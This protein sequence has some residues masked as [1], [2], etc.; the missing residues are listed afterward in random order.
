MSNEQKLRDYLKRV[1][2]DLHQVRQRLSEVEDNEREPIAIVGM[3]CRFP[4]GVNSP[5]GL[6]RLL[7]DGTDA[8]SGFPGNRGWDVDAL[9]DPDP[10]HR[11]TA[12]VREG[13]F[14]HD[15][16]G[17][18]ASLFGISPREAAAMD[19]QQRLLLEASWEVFERAGI[20]PTSV[21]GSRTGVFAGTS[22]QDYGSELTSIPPEVEGYLGTGLAAA[23]LSGR[24]AYTFGLEGPAVTVDTACSSSLVAL[25]LAAQALRNGE[26]TMAL[27]GG[28][29]V[30]TTPGTFVEFSRQRGLASD[31]RC[32]AFAAAA[33]GTGWGEG[34][35]VLLVERLSDARRNGHEVLALLRGSAVNQD[36]ASS[37]LTAPNGPSQ[38]RV[39]RQALASARLSPSQVD[40]V[41]AHGTGTTLG[42]PIEAQ[43]LL[44]TYG[45]DR[46]RPLWLGSVKSNIGHTQAAAGVAGVIKMVEA[47]RHGV[48]PKTLHVDEPTP[49]V[50]WSSGAVSLLT[51]SVAWPE[52]GAPRRAAVSAFGVSGTNVHTVLEQAPVD[53]AAEEPRVPVTRPVPWVLAGRT[54]EA[55]RAQAAELASTVDGLAP[56]D[57]AFSLATTRAALERRAVVVGRDSDEFLRGLR[58]LAEGSVAPNL[59]TGA[60]RDDASLAVLFSGQGSQRAGMGRELYG[61]FPVFASALDAVCAEL[62]RHLD[63][64]I[65]EL[66]FAEDGEPLNQTQYTQA[67]L[68]ALE[69]AL[70]RLVESWGIRPDFVTGHSIGELTAAHVAG[71]LSLPDAAVLVA[72]RGRFMQAL[73]A[74]GA[75]L[76]VQAT[77]NE[78]KPLLEGL[79]DKVSIAAV[80]GPR[81]VVVAG[82]EDVIAG[83]ESAWIWKTKRLTVSHAFHSP[84][85]E[86]M[87]AD[88]RTIAQAVTLQAP[89]IPVVS[90]VT[91]ETADVTDPEYWVRHVRET[92]RFADGV[93]YLEGQGVSAF[94][95]LGPDGILTGM[96]AESLS[97]A[98]LVPALRR[99]RDEAEVLT[100][101]L[102]RLHAAGVRIDWPA[103]FDGTGAH[104][105]DLPT[106]A[107]QHE[108]Y[109]LENPDE[110][111]READEVDGH[112]WDAVEREDL[113]VLASTL[114]VGVDD[115]LSAVL[116]ALSAW[117]RR[118]REQSTVDG[119][120][121]GV[122]WRAI[123]DPA[124]ALSG[125]WLLVLPDEGRFDEA[126]RVLRD[127]GAQ[128]RPLVLAEADLDRSSLAA[129]LA[130]LAAD[131]PFAGVLSL[132][133]LDERPHAEFPV[134]PLGLSG[135]LTLVQA[136]EESGVDGP[137]WTVTSGA[138]TTGDGAPVNPVQAQIWGLARTVP[139][140]HPERWG[141][142]VDLPSEADE[143][144]WSRLAG[145]LAAGGGEDQVAVRASGVFGRRLVHAPAADEAAWSCDG[146]VLVTGGT[147]AL[148]AR[149]ARW[150]VASGAEHVVLTSRRGSD[151]EGA[152]ELEAELV[153]AGARVTIAACD[154]A[155]RE[156]A[157][158][159]V[160]SLT[161]LSAV[162]HVAGVVDDGVLDSL[163]LERVARVLQP[164]VAGAVNL[165]ELTAGMDLSAFV[166]FSSFSGTMG[167]PGQ[168]GYA[169][170][171]AFLDA[172]AE[173]RHA[174]GLPATSIAWGPWAGAGMA[175]ADAVTNRG[176]A[177]SMPLLDPE[178]ALT[179]MGRI[180]AR[181]ETCVGIVDLDWTKFAAG[182]PSDTPVPL[183]DEIPDVRRALEAAKSD[184]DT[185]AVP[186]ASALARRLTGLS[187]TERV[188]VL[189]DVVRTQ[190]AVVLGHQHGGQIEPDRAF[191]DLGF[192][193][194]SALEFRNQLGAAV[195]LSLPAT[196]IFDYPTPLALAEHLAGAALGADSAPVAAAATDE[197]IAIIGMSCRFPGGVSTPEQL[198]ELLVSGTDALTEFPADRGWDIERLYHPDRDANEP[199][200]SYTR[201]GGFL[202]DAAGFDSNFFGIS[203]R[204]ALAMD[205]QQRLLLE[206][207]W[208]A[209]ERAGIDPAAMRGSQTGVFAGSSGQDYL[210]VVAES[211]TGLGGHLGT[212]N[213]ASVASGRVSYTFG[214]EGPAMTVDTACSSS[215]VALHLACQSLRQGECTMALAGG[216]T[217]MATPGLFVEFS[218]QRGLATDGR[219][220]AF[221]DSADGTGW[222]EGVGLLLVER[223][224]DAQR[225]GH[226]I[227]AVV[228]GSAVNQDGASN[229]LTAPNG[230]SQQR[231][232]RQALANA[233][234]E[235][236]DVDAVEAHGT[237][238]TL[239]DPIEAQALLATYGQG[240]KEPLWLGSVKS[241]IGHT[242]AAAGVAGVIKMVLALRHGVL[243][244]T[245]HVDEPSS[246]VDWSSGA[247]SLVTESMP[248]PETG[249][250]RRAGISSFGFSGT[251]AHT[252]LEQA[253]EA[254]PVRDGAPA[255]D[256]VV[257]WVLSARGPS[258]LRAQAA[259]LLSHTGAHPELNTADIAFSLAATR[260]TLDTRA[261]VLGADREEL[262]AGLAA[263]A[264]GD[265]AAN[266][267]EGL[268]GGASGKVAFVFPG[269]GSQW[270][271]M[272]T[273]LL[274]SSA[275]FASRFAE[276]EHALSSFVDWSLTEAV[277]DE[278][279]L[280][281]VDVVQPVLWAVMVS[282]AEVW[283]SYGVEPAA[284][285][286][287]S[288][289]EIAA[290][291]VAGALSLEDGA[292]V[293]ALRSQTIRDELAGQGGM[294]S[295]AQPES[296]VVERIARFGDR[297][298]V[299]AVNG[300]GT[301]VIAGEPEALAEILAECEAE[302]VRARKIAVDYASHTPQVESIRDRL[303][304]VL[305][306]IQPRTGEVGFFSTL[307]GDWQDTT[308]LDAR[309]W[310]E[311]LRHTVKFEQA[312]R[313]LSEQGYGFFVESSAHPVLTMSVQETLDTLET[314]G[315]AVGT[316]RRNE[317]GVD[318]FLTSL[319]EAYVQGLTVDWASSFDGAARVDLP[320]YAFQHERYWPEPVAAEP[321]ATTDPMADRFWELVENEDLENLVGTLDVNRDAPL[322]DVLP[323]L[324]AWRREHR[325]QSVVDGWRYRITWKRLGAD[326]PPSLS[327]TWLVLGSD[328]S[329]RG[330]ID[331][332]RRHGA[333]T[334]EVTP[335]DLADRETM[336]AA[337]REAMDGAGVTP[338][339]VI[340]VWSLLA[341]AENPLPDL[342]AV[343]SGMAGTLTLLQALGDL[344]VDA[345]LWCA[346]RG[347]VAVTGADP[348]DH[349]GQALV[350]GLGRIAGLEYE[351][352][353]GGLVDLPDAVGE[354]AQD[355]LAGVLSG[356]G[357]EDQL[358]IRESGVYGRRLVRARAGETPVKRA[359]RPTGTAL[360][361]GGTGALGGQVARWLA[362]NGAEHLLLLSRRGSDAPG[363]AELTDE[364]TALGARVTIAACDVSDRD[365]LAAV[366][367]EIPAEY[368]L[369]S[370]LHTAAVLDDT[371]LELL[372]PAQIDRVLRV[373]MRAAENL[374]ELTGEL[375]A[376]VLFSSLSGTLGAS[377]QGNYAPGNAYLDALAHH[378]RAR[379]Q[380]ATSVAWGPWDG[381]GMAESGIGEIA[382]RHGVPPMSPE[383]AVIALQQALDRD[384]TFLTVADI[385]WERY[386]VAYTATRPTGLFDELAEVTRLLAAKTDTAGGEREDAPSEL[387]G[388]LAGL[389]AAEQNRLL[390]ELV[391]GHVA[392]VLGYSSADA[393]DERRSFKDLG[394]DSVTA[395]ELRNRLGGATG[396]RLPAT[397]VFDYPA[398]ADLAAYLRTEILGA[399]PDSPVTTTVS[400][401]ADEPVAIVAMSCRFPGGVGSPEDLWRLVSGSGDA[402]GELP[403]DRGWDLAAL[404]DDD[405]GRAGTSYSRA[406]G[407]LYEAAEFDPGLFGISPREALA[408]DPQQR[409]VLEAAW[410][411]FERGG[412]DP[413]SLRGSDAGVFLGACSQGYGS[414]IIE[415][416]EGV[417]GYF[418]TGAA[419]S[420]MSG[421]IAY[422][423]GL[424]GP[425][426]TVDTACSSSLVALHLAAQAL[427]AGE[428][429]LAVAGGVTVM[430]TPGSFSEFSRQRGLAADGKCKAFAASADGFGQGEGLGLLLM[431]RLSDAKR[432]GHQVLAVL[433]GSAVNQDGASNGLTAPN[434]PSQQRVIRQALA[435]ARLEP[436][437][438]DA[439]EA[440]G[441][442]TSLGDPIEAQ[443]VLATYGQ[444][445]DE[446][447]W[448]GSVKSNIGH[449]Q[450]AAGVAGVIKMVLAMR[451]G[452]LPPTLH[453]DEP[454][455]HVDWSSGAVSLVTESMPWPETGRPRRVGVSSFGF[456]GTNAH[457]ILEQAEPVEVPAAE[458]F[459]GVVPWVLSGKT[460]AA[461][462]AQANRLASFAA[463]HGELS[464]ADVGLSLTATR[465]ALES[466]GVVIGS[467]P[468]A[469]LEGLRALASGEVAPNSVAGVAD[470]RG[471]VVFV[472]PGQG[473]QWVG[474]AVDLLSFSAVFASRFAECERAL[475]SFVDWSLT[476]VVGD[477]GALERVDVVQPVLW[478]VMVSLA[479]VWRSFGV[480]PAAVVGH[481][482]GEIAAAVVA[483]A[484][485]LEDGARVVALRSQAIRDEL[486]GKGGMV[487]IAQPESAVV[488]RISRFGDR[489]AVAA[490]NGPGTTVIAGEPEA[491]AEILA[492]C[493]AEEVRARKIA[494]D[495]ASHTPQVESIRDRLL[496][497]LSPIQP[498]GTETG[499]FSTLT[500]DWQDTTGLD[501]R[502]WVE[503]LRHTVKFE[504]ATRALV[505]QGYRFFIESSAHPVLTMSVQETFDTTDTDGVAFGSLRRNEGGLDRFLTS[506]A[507]GYVR[508]LDVDWTPAYPS[509][510]RR[511]ELP[512][513]AFQR[514]RYWLES[515][516]SVSDLMAADVVEARFWD[517]VE[518]EDLEALATTLDVDDA[519]LG[520]L[521][522]ALSS[523]RRQRRQQSTVD[524][525]RYTVSWKPLTTATARLSGTWLLVTAPGHEDTVWLAEELRAHGADV[526]TIE[527]GE[528][529]RAGLTARI[530]EQGEIAGV[531]SLLGT[532][533]RPCAG[534]P[535]LPNGIADTVTL[536]QALVDS[537]VVAPVWLA[538]RGGVSVGRSDRAADP[539]QAQV[540]GLGRILGLEHPDRWGGLLDLPATAD[541]RAAARVVA[542]LAGIEDEDQVAVRDSG[543]FARRLVRSP[544][545]DRDAV[546]EWSP[547]GTVLVTGGTGALGGHVAR[548]LA[549]NGAE[550][551]VLTSRRGRDA[552]GAVELE[553]ALTGLGARVTI[554]ACDAADRDALAEL[555]AEYGP[556]SAVV[557]TAGV[558]QVSLLADQDL[559]D[560][561]STVEAKVAGAA[562]LDE[563]LGDAE[564]DAFV[565]FSS[566]AGVWG[567]GAQG[568]YA[569][570]NAFLDALAE[571]RRARG[572]TA[573]SIAW[574]AW[575]GSGLATTE[576]AEENLRRRGVLP[577]APEAAVAA[578]VQ[579]VEHDETFVAVAD[580]DWARFVP[581]FT[582]ARPR[583]LISDI[584]EARQAAESSYEGADAA[585]GTELVKRLAG[586]SE[587]ERQRTVV[588]LVRTTAAAVLGLAGASEVPP[589]RAFRDLG[590]DSLTAVEIRNRL[591]AATGLKLPTALVFDY[592]NATVLAEFLVREVTGAVADVAAPT[593]VA[594]VGDDPVVIV[595]MACRYPGGVNS[596]EQFWDLV[597]SGGDGISGFPTDRGWDLD[598]IS[599]AG[600]YAPEGGFVYDA[601]EFDAAFFGIS[602]REARAM[603]P[604]Q[605][606]VLEAAWETLERAGIDPSALR[607]SQTGVFVGAASQGYGSGFYQADPDAME[608]YL[609][610][611]DAGSVVSGR[612]S[613]ALGLEGPAVTVDTACSSSL[614]AL[615]WA[616]QSVRSGESSLALAGGVAVMASAGAFAEFGKQ[617][618]LAGDGRCKPFAEAAD[619]TGWGEGVGMVLLERLSDAERNGH[620]VLAVIRGS[621]V[622]QDGASNGLTAPNGPS[623]QRVIR[624][625]L[626]NA[627]LTA[628]EVD[629]VEAH[630]TGTTL[631]DP[632]EAQA[633]LA[634]YG[635]DRERP[636]LL[637][638]VKSNIGHTQ[639]ASGVAG[640]IKMVQA[641]RHGVLP[642]TL[643]IDE[644]STHVD[645]S[646][647]AVSLL[648]DTTPWPETGA[649][650]RAGVSAFGVSGTNVH[651]ILE[652]APASH[653]EE[654]VR[655]DRPLPWVLSGKTQDAVRAQASRLLS[656]V[657]GLN[658]ADIAFSLATT[659]AGLD[660]RAALTG[661]GTGGFGDGLRALADGRSAPGVVTGTA[662]DGGTAILFSGQGSQRAGMGKQLYGEFPV[663]ADALDAVCAYLDKSLDRPV[664]EL[665]FAEDGEQLNQTQYT[666]ASLFA[667]EVALYRLVESW[668]IRPDF[669]TGHSIGE[670]TAAHVAGVLSLED[671]A[672]LVAARGRLM[673]ALPTGGAMLSVRATENDI[674]PLLEGLEDKVSIAA[675][676]GPASVVVAG[677]EDVIAGFESAWEWKTKRLTVSHAFHSPR[678]EPM[679][680]DFRK[681]A[682]SLTFE[683]PKVPVVSNVTGAVADV[684][685][686][687][688]WV[689]HVR[690]AVRFADGVQYLAGQ[691][692]TTFL[693][694]GPDGVLT[695][696]AQD[697]APEATH[698]PALRRDR[699][700]VEATTTAVA[701]L[702]VSGVLLDWQAYFAG[703]GARTVDLPTYPFQRQRYWLEAAEAE[704]VGDD[705]DV[706][707]AQ[708]WDAVEREDLES[709]TGTLRIDG[710]QP[711]SAVLPALSSWRRQRRD[712]STVDDWRYQI[713]WK[714]VTADAE[715]ALS[716]TWLVVVPTEAGEHDW[717]TGALDALASGGAE[718][719]RLDLAESELDRAVLAERIASAVGE[720]PLSGV[721]SLLGF[722]ERPHS[723]D[724][725]VPV[726][727]FGTVSLLQ[728]LADAGLEVPLWLGT[729]GAVS[730]GRSDRLTSPVQAHLWGIGRVIG[731]EQPQRWGGLVDLP[732]T[733]TARLGARL[734]AALAGIDD[735]DQL[736]VR[737]SSV[738]GRRLLRAPAGETTAKWQPKGTV[739]ITGGTGALGGHVARWLAANGAERLV[740]TS[741]RGGAAAG[742]AE[743]E[744]ELTG[745][746][747][748]VSI[749]AC[750]VADRE[751]L[752][753]LVRR[754][755]AE[756]SPIRA[757][758]H[759]AG[760]GQSTSVVDM[761]LA[762]IASVV[763]AKVTG[764]TNLHEL[765]ADGGL[766]AFVLFSSIA[767]VWGSGVQGAYAAGNAYL[768]ALAE[769]RRFDGL[770]ATSV[771]W[772]PW[773]EGGLASGAV[774]EQLLRRGLRQLA[775]GLAVGALVQSVGLDETCVTVADVDWARFV[776]GYTLSGPSALISSVPEAQRA[777]EADA[778]T[779]G[780]DES[781]AFAREI[782]ALSS[783]ERDRKLLNLVRTKVAEVLG[784]GGLDDI[785]AD[786]S[787]QEL[788]FDSLTAVELR[789]QLTSVTGVALPAT[790]VFD[791]PTPTALGARLAEEL[792]PE[793]SGTGTE[794]EADLRRALA[795]IPVDRLREAGLLDTLLRLADSPGPEPA[796]D[797]DEDVDD[798]IDTMDIENLIEI[799]LDGGAAPEAD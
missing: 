318:R 746:G 267:V 419:T 455:P 414:D 174:E 232:I 47:M 648:T 721:L 307:T 411:V 177:H 653:T 208:E 481:S 515:T 298:A 54:D 676:N 40:V 352:R 728:S 738:F 264:G 719:V 6:W 333:R 575:G 384:E 273:D 424:E 757:V 377:G 35:G 50:D 199:G 438:V 381:G 349:P 518:R 715:A 55:L 338:A 579:S 362:E 52:T 442:G 634:T 464:A 169:A 22:G 425:A 531:L 608:G 673:Q 472:F 198:W 19:P 473:S 624:Q 759:T 301:T 356:R 358:A 566:N 601:S 523:W 45:Q 513:Y 632:I 541:D 254:E 737:D 735:E 373:K 526:V 286:G 180:L 448:L 369:T 732:A 712:Q 81:S 149:V 299:A 698:I 321:V 636:L 26:C 33:D 93:R 618:G 353:W 396:L 520:E 340:G 612:V 700:E 427:R 195:V 534:H 305:D 476:E 717:V 82:D 623:Q 780:G 576:V 184:S 546:R 620:E 758:V 127:S 204:E 593:A 622:N 378:R 390:L 106:Y 189:L 537:A 290:A 162:F 1:T 724:P 488:E 297:V 680:A 361:T 441:T 366:L 79:E 730:V 388:R 665:M 152:P 37:G 132:L 460:D 505:E 209:F 650:R 335:A 783:S 255:P 423:L 501:A 150:L 560:F 611:G 798:A 649:P 43:A 34:V 451:H 249:H 610:T 410:E 470:V 185:A 781:A 704:P 591:S 525:W 720:R 167:S 222:G 641:M 418:V 502:Y 159:L 241:N 406:G 535:V 415:A 345:P 606:I 557:H 703:T 543:V 343:P 552:D 790:L 108:H 723:G 782:A 792:L 336:A 402:I 477:E 111:A 97:D 725:A 697:T 603:D 332:L 262:L 778:D 512:T 196:L 659:R 293:V 401:V 243:P 643:H 178:L 294:V 621:A 727:V 688:Y 529:D 285:V 604:Q 679:L 214:F 553:A 323:V 594:E 370:V 496:D 295:I 771:A 596:P 215:L 274:S 789:N 550:H 252:V 172:L 291:V 655:V 211:A 395:V 69:V 65:K 763:G 444:G 163:T 437:E 58:A 279:L 49:Q 598:G 126:E 139:L 707:D 412:I 85:M 393:A 344:R 15:A 186:A 225:N 674:A 187:R 306:P 627:G 458:P 694:L 469:R 389:G 708:F 519:S 117:R 399:L 554:A 330:A 775:P 166:L 60:S 192:D 138:V 77:E 420:V 734:V 125:T 619:G 114:Q 219:C 689:R 70:Y 331:A 587:V 359:W 642:K 774:G 36:G 148:G 733:A 380:V 253:P 639:A 548:W 268:P 42:D 23:V 397:L 164:K 357:V 27:A 506:L 31:G 671:A 102:G 499:F 364:L 205:P 101:A 516:V 161:E 310:V 99:D 561:A 741:R 544:L 453:V 722:D 449:A 532:D 498:R 589:G 137:L 175:A 68:F 220:R 112:F 217:V 300:P 153:A 374:H 736:A 383:L 57:V 122:A 238:T 507:E 702:Y 718:T 630:G 140:E 691:G 456:S 59:V 651:T 142:L 495:Y 244:K 586:L 105:V 463:E 564:L 750:D 706:V 257:P 744:A 585:G 511:V 337:V 171:N 692:V 684:T 764:A 228:R 431:E 799:A 489:V 134:L 365:S 282:L 626:A 772:G 753:A 151:A 542:V 376:F 486:A 239:G 95:E 530:D 450:Q 133:G 421:R 633:V 726:G 308:G 312:T 281:R 375:S 283:R 265:A 271:G 492:E 272:A 258:A 322:H 182:L 487:S 562:H 404:F 326:V 484:L 795:T 218:A 325:E 478:A 465:S 234:L 200:T 38:Q 710:D 592:P 403:S 190:A 256:G 25:H 432:N 563:L 491:L 53:D 745:L 201:E 144:A 146:T 447:V 266:V 652:Q 275:V 635:Q 578:L 89:R 740:L 426:M 645:W 84:R 483:G 493:E 471:K 124:P 540:W 86:P 660:H 197:P 452:V 787:F 130:E 98:A 503:N 565:L 644:P 269:Q 329:D 413:L 317:G 247:V 157:A 179:A 466:R 747:A 339:E 577:M 761:D 96:A 742:A 51:D 221:A 107:F 755:A 714:P 797:E 328:G 206:A 346:T 454:T 467:D 482:Q 573:T 71:V 292:R 504:Q 385:N 347:A 435:N 233:R 63:R 226:P 752:E 607:G 75:M 324:S 135:T 158:E 80:N 156:A 28:V 400:V 227:L 61:E 213:A 216:A 768:D 584:P 555:L 113:Q 251:N 490:V 210:N 716:G 32:K 14:V 711:L 457:A 320:T 696:M 765:F 682:E 699:G 664:K 527:A 87:L 304:D 288:Q 193:S 348:V 785:E 231:V 327:G 528:L 387:A 88:F 474:M 631:G 570:G 116:P 713:G 605:R 391:R 522:P 235:A 367:A 500:G 668:G 617:G 599:A 670:L 250:P 237:G 277:R 260:S 168:A 663:F 123:A 242:V 638:A 422:T 574:G 176:S 685:D 24:V 647:G 669:V 386:V 141:G 46:E 559:A 165:H 793:E 11:G 118:R 334:V 73:P 355:R 434:G 616:A 508:G 408:M 766:D 709:L 4:G 748:K 729:R 104:R 212:G 223:L 354:T 56:A 656:H 3:S 44:A 494:V 485:S 30:M 173:Q 48:L 17:F 693:E 76:S 363:A 41:E 103:Y 188:D 83:F 170:A 302:E 731:L 371:V 319:G 517:A 686:P 595:G 12:Y 677:D 590:F 160:G 131:G 556:F 773:D 687:D 549:A 628:T 128:V 109:W 129:E 143:R 743:L 202:D 66:M 786:R 416:P 62:D 510:A 625:A 259:R 788:G 749:E 459:T 313:A 524:Q 521:L 445:R 90:N 309:Y 136:L 613:Y 629:A 9:F 29:T 147:G 602:P 351:Q 784:H 13:G 443:A 480:E 394:F 779:G 360:V 572:V 600:A 296:A 78:I 392:T 479:A 280:E 20:D 569:A 558:V 303:L 533:T 667:L 551:L 666:Q 181:D 509:D 791:Y 121:Y 751:A 588:E 372:E 662:R 547:R 777:M 5:E 154:V 350:W 657:D 289:G 539:A 110:P 739:L 248:W 7:A 446:P 637:G 379:G 64:S 405:P 224:S 8:M 67:S 583:P 119:W 145:V 762:E 769:Q 229:G 429:S 311:N 468:E 654:H 207:S 796:A 794:D 615:H 18:D 678:M 461:L 582:A 683:A 100:V 760:V 417:E 545:A 433:R 538:T 368:P 514:Q 398:P 536:I 701:R 581:G 571:Q 672:A 240:R 194:L 407:F 92:V 203:P 230:P 263:L 754:Y 16:G 316:L 640:V 690:H 430:S 2:A 236:S 314:E 21:R 341:L 568:A 580:V 72:A 155:D 74:G 675:I 646:T 567:S 614:V 115:P 315:V 246:H 284:V 770:P 94:L 270:V 342:P 695:G 462:R 276:C 658:E 428:C 681:V 120:R 609:T 661:F 440:H 191:R 261:V 597:E 705:R 278:A 91:G 39:I 475:S 756:E 245:L 439:V 409:L 382:S 497:V 436:S 767:G 287:H 776:P 183:L 10:D